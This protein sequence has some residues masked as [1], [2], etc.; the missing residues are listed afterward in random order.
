MLTSTST[1]KHH[2]VTLSLARYQMY[3]DEHGSSP[4]THATTIQ[5][6]HFRRPFFLVFEQSPQWCSSYLPLF[7]L[8]VTHGDAQWSRRRRPRCLVVLT[9]INE[10]LISYD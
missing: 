5:H 10:L 9:V 2:S 4:A 3:A 1:L 7:I 6:H 8:K